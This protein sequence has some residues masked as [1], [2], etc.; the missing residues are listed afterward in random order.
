M[1][2]RRNSSCNCGILAIVLLIA[3]S[4]ACHGGQGRTTG[5]PEAL[6]KRLPAIAESGNWD[7]PWF[8]EILNAEASGMTLALVEAIGSRE[9]FQEATQSRIAYLALLLIHAEKT[10]AGRAQLLEGLKSPHTAVRGICLEAITPVAREHSAD[11][12]PHLIPLWSDVG[13]SLDG[14]M[15]NGDPPLTTKGTV[16]L[17]RLSGKFGPDGKSLVPFL[18]NAFRVEAQEVRTE[19]AAAIMSILGVRDAL[20]LLKAEDPQSTGHVVMA[21]GL[22]TV[23]AGVAGLLESDAAAARETCLLAT[24]SPDP[25]VRTAA[26]RNLESI[27]LSEFVIGLPNGE[28]AL[29]PVLR[30]RLERINAKDPDIRVREAAN[31][32]L[33]RKE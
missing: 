9:D 26:I 19:I 22:V 24:E 5:T 21:L 28:L 31:D 17:A 25:G 20:G 23:R 11:V 27:F 8:E 2:T 15:K 3:N 30:D 1:S 32:V 29:N 6:V 16:A 33:S 4:S 12:L 13:R 14:S 10:E 7:D 18:E